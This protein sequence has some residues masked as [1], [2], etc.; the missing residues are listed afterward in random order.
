MQSSIFSLKYFLAEFV[1]KTASVFLAY[2]AYLRGFVNEVHDRIID[3]IIKSFVASTDK[4]DN[5]VIKIRQPDLAQICKTGVVA[6]HH[7]VIKHFKIRI[8]R[9]DH[10]TDNR[11]W[12]VVKSNRASI[13]V[14]RRGG[15]P[16]R[17][18]P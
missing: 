7:L 14:S 8:A 12:I 9:L 4:I 1:K 10:F 15:T 16:I 11:G 2:H 13:P 3:I 5:T 18:W 17:A 6:Y